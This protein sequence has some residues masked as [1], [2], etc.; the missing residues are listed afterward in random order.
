VIT[1]GR[2]IDEI[3]ISELDRPG[4]RRLGSDT[5]AD[6]DWPVWSPDGASIA[7]QRT[8]R[9][10]RDGVYMQSSSG[11][12]ARLVLTPESD[13]VDYSPWSWM[14][15]GATLLLSRN[16]AG[17]SSLVAL[18]LAGNDADS[19]RTHR[20]ASSGF[21]AALPRIS[22]DGHWLAYLSDE[23]GK[24]EL[25][26]AEF[27][28]DGT[29]GT[30]VRASV[31]ESGLSQWSADGKSLFYFQFQEHVRLWKVSVATRPTLAISPPAEVL[32]LDKLGLGSGAV[33]PDG[34]YLVTV[35]GEGE[36]QLTRYNLV[37]NWTSE[38]ERKLQA[39]R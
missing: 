3:W 15:D 36:D 24:W 13:G 31:G 38:L 30:P 27:H 11:G 9:D 8:A 29:T 21:N 25:Y 10:G 18:T 22:P 28:Q 12:E 14:P 26:V 23:T 20:I 4:L 6:C 1:N 32:D 34:R 17:R 2:A 35:K 37:L 7:Y 33:L 39:A 5:A 19:S 16:V